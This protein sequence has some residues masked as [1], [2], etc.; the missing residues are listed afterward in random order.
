MKFCIKIV[1]LSA[2]ETGH[3]VL[4]S[5]DAMNATET[6]QRLI[7]FFPA[8]QQHTARMSIAGTLKGVLCQRLINK[9]DGIGRVP[10]CEVML[11]N[12][13]IFDR[14]SDISGIK[15]ELEDVIADGEY[16][17]MQSMDQ[18]LLQLFG[19]GHITRRETLSNAVNPNELRSMMEAVRSE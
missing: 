10:A 9:L 13:R 19:D 4:A 12:S 17:G 3:L 18:A 16:Y 7:D 15:L 8:H 1:Y 14:I 2:A 5:F 11:V 6:V